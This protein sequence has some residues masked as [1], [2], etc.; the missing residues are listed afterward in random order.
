VKMSVVGNGKKMKWVD[1]NALCDE[2]VNI[3]FL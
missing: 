2:D 1:F 3:V